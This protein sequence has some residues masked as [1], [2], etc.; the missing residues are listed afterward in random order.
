MANIMTNNESGR[1]AALVHA[2]DWISRGSF[3]GIGRRAGWSGALSGAVIAAACSTAA[4][5]PEGAQVVRG[6]V[7]ITRNGA[8]TLI[9]AGHN[10][11]INYRSFDIGSHESVRFIQPNAASRVL[12]RINSAAPTRIEGALSANGRVYI[13]NPAGVIFGNGARVN[14]AGLYA[15]GGKL[16]NADFLAGRNRFT[17]L[18]GEVANHGTITADFA[19]LIGHRVFNSGSI[20]APQGTV[21]MAAGPEV[22]VGE[23]TGNVFVKITGPAKNAGGAGVDNAGVVEAAGGRVMMGAGDMYSLAVRTTGRVK[24]K[25]IDVGVGKGH[26]TVSGTL[27]ASNQGAGETGG[28]VH[29]LGDSISLINAKIDASGANG[30]GQVR[31]GGDYLGQGDLARAKFTSVDKDSSISVSAGQQGDGGTAIV[32]SDQFTEYFGSADA[33]GGSQGGDGGLIETSSKDTVNL[34]PAS[35][36]ASAAKGQGGNWLIDPRDVNISDAA[37]AFIGGNP[38]FTPG[39]GG[40]GPSNVNIGTV[41]AALNAGTSVTVTTA[42]S[43]EGHVGNIVVLDSIQ[44]TAGGNATLTLT[45]MGSITIN[46]NDTGASPLEISS[47][48]GTLGVILQANA[49]GGVGHSASGSGAVNLNGSIITN[50]GVFTSSGVNFTSSG[51]GTI[52]TTGAANGAI[53]LTHTGTVAVGGAM[54]GGAVDIDSGAG[55]ISLNANITTGAGAVRFRDAVTLAT[56]VTIDTTSGNAAGAGITFDSTINGTAAGQEDLDL[57][58]GTG[59]NIVVTGAAGGT[60][61]LGLLNITNANNVNTGALTLAGMEQDAG[62]G[63]STFGGAIDTDNGGVVVTGNNFTFSGLV[64]TGAGGQLFST[65][66]GA[67]AI[68]AGASLDGGLV[69]AGGGTISITGNVTTTNDNI[70]I[71]DALTFGGASTLNAG[72]AIIAFGS[73]AAAGANNVILNA[74]AINFNGGANSVTGTGTLTLR[75]STDAATISVGAAGGDLE[76]TAADMAALA[77]GFTQINIGRATTGAHDI[78]IGALAIRD[79]MVF[80]ASATGGSVLVSGAITGS[81]DGAVTINGSGAT[82]TLDANIVTAGGAIQ[83]NDAVVLGTSVTLDTTNG[84]AVAAGANIGITGTIEATTDSTEALTM[85][86]GTGGDITLGGAVGGTQRLGGFTITS[87]DDVTAG[88]IASTFITQTLA[89]NSATYSGQLD[90]TDAAGIS[91][92][93]A[94]IS[95]NGSAT[96]TNGGTFSVNNSGALTIGGALNLDGA[97]TQTGAGAVTVSNNI[98][99]SND[100]VSFAANVT[101]GNDIVIDTN[102]G[103]GGDVTFSGTLNGTTAGADNLTIDAGSGDVFFTSIGQGTRI[104]ILTITTA[105]DVSAAAANMLRMV[106][107]AGTGTTSFSGTVDTSSGGLNVT[108]NNFTF[109]STINTTAG[110]GLTVVSTGALT[111]NGASTLDGSL[112][113]SGGGTAALNANVTT[114]NDNISITG[115]ATVGS[116]AQFTVGT[117]I[118]AFTGTVG[119][120][121]NN[122]TFT[123]DEINFNGGAGSVTGTGSIVLQSGTNG[124]T[125]NV[126]NAVN[127]AGE[128]D[129]Q[130][131]DINALADG[132]TQIT[133]GRNTGVQALNIS[134]S[135]FND[136]VVFRAGGGGTTTVAGALTG[137]GNASFTITGTSAVAVNAAVTTAGGNF[138]SAGTT[139]TSNGAGT[140]STSNGLFTLAHTGAVTLGGN[141][142]TG[143]FDVD[144]GAGGISLGASILTTGDAVRFRDAVTLTAD[145]SINTTS[146]TAVGNNITF[147]GTVSGTTSGAEDLTLVA[148]TGGDISFGGAVGGTRLGALAITSADVVTGSSVTAASFSQAAGT[149]STTLSGAVNTNAAG[150]VSLSGNAFTL[151]A[152]TTTGGGTFTANNSGT[153]TLGGT[154]TLDGA[155]SQTGAGATQ[156][157]AA[158]TTTNDNISFNGDVTV[159]AAIGGLN[160]GTAGLTFGGLLSLGANP[161]TLTGNAMAFNGG[162]DSVSGTGALTIQGAA[163]ATNIG[164][165]VDP[166]VGGL[167]LTNATW[168]ALADGFSG[169]TVGRSN[170]SGTM[171]LGT[172]TVRDAVVFQMPS[173]V[174]DVSGVITSTGAGTTVSLVGDT[175][176]GGGSGISTDNEAISIDGDVVLAAGTTT[177]D[178]SGAG[179]TGANIEITGAVT[180]AAADVAELEFDAGTTGNITIGGDTGTNAVPLL[181]FGVVSAN[182]VTTEDIFAGQIAQQAGGGTSTFGLLRS[183]SG[184]IILTGNNFD[185]NQGAASLAS[186][187]MT[188][189]NAGTLTVDGS[190]A[191]TGAFTQTGGGVALN[192]NLSTTNDNISIGGAT[193]AGGAFAAIN[194]GTATITLGSTFAMGAINGTFTANDMVFGGGADSISGTGQITLQP[195]AAATSIGIAGGAGTLQLGAADIGALADGFDRLTIGR[196]DGQHAITIGA[197]TFRDETVIRTPSGGTISVTGAIF[198]DGDASVSLTSAGDITLGANIVTAGNEITLTGPIVLGSGV[199]LDTTDGGNA[200]GADLTLA[201]TVQGTTAGGQSLTLD[202]GAGNIALG[203]N[204]G[205]T[206]RLGALSVTG[207]VLYS[208]ATTIRST[209]APF[210]DAVSG[211]DDL[212]I[213]AG[214]GNLTLNGVVSAGAGDLVLAGAAITQNAAVSGA[215]YAVQAQNALAINGDVTAT[216]A[217][218]ILLNA[219]LSGAGNLTF[220]AGVDVNASAMTLSAGVGTGTAVADLVTNSPVFRGAAGGATSPGFFQYRQDANI[221]GASLPVVAGQFGGG[222]A[223]MDYRINARNGTVTMD[224]ASR[225]AGSALRLTSTGGI[226]T[227]AD[228]SLAS[229]RATSLISYTGNVTTSNGAIQ[230]DAAAQTLGDIALIAG[231]GTITFS[232]TLAV[233]GSSLTLIAGDVEFADAVTPGAPVTLSIQHGDASKD[234]YLGG[235]GL[236]G[237]GDMHLTAAEIARLGDG[238]ADINIG[239]TDSTGTIFVRTAVTFQDPVA[240]VAADTGAA[241]RVEALLSGIDDAS[242]TLDGSGA[243]TVLLADIRTAGQA[244]T[245]NDKVI[246]GANVTL[247]TTDSGGVATGADITINGEVDADAA[248]QDRQLTLNSGT[249]GFVTLQ[250]VGLNERLGSLSA[251]GDEIFLLSVQTRQGQSYTGAV[252]LEGDLN[253]SVAGAINISGDLLVGADA[254]IETAGLTASDDIRITGTVNSV[255]SPR[256]LTM[257]AGQGSVGVGGSV[258]QTLA[259]SNLSVTG[260]NNEFTFVTTSNG[261]TY[262]GSTTIGGDLSGSTILFNDGLTLDNSV[263]MSGSIS[264]TLNTVLSAATEGNSLTINSPTTVFNGSIGNTAGG[265]LG[266]ITSDAGG[267]LTVRGAAVRSLGAQAYGDAVSLDANVTFASNGSVTFGSTINSA[268]GN[269]NLTVNTA[270]GMNTVFAGAIGQTNALGTLTTNAG[271]TAF[272]GGNVRTTG[273]QTINDAVILNANTTFQGSALTFGSTINSDATARALTFLATGGTVTVADA[274]GGT[275]ALASLSSTS[276]TASL[277]SVTTAGGQSITGALT[278]NGALA[279]TTNGTIEIT[280]PLT[281]AGDSSIT[282]AGG[283]GNNIT[284]TGEVNASPESALAVN[285]GSGNVNFI[286]NIGQTNRLSSLTVQAANISAHDVATTGAQSY[287]GVLTSDG[288]MDSSVA[289]DI[290][291][292]GNL[293]LSGDVTVATAA[294]NITYGGTVD[295]G[296]NLITAATGGVST[297]NGVVGGVTRL[298]TVTSNGQARLNGASV[299]TTGDQTYNAG[300]VLGEDVV[301]EAQDITFNGTIDSDDAG[302]PRALTVN[303]S[304]S[305]ETRFFGTVGGTAAL[306]RISTNADGITKVGTTMTTIGGMTFADALRITADSTLNGGAGSLFFRNAI[307]ADANATNPLLTLLSTAAADGDTTPFMFNA[308]IGATRQ[309]GGLTLGA[310]RSPP[311]G[312]TA[313][314]SD[315][316]QANGRILESSFNSADNFTIRTGDGGFTMGRGQKLTTFGSLNVTTT[317]IATLGDLTALTNIRVIANAIRIQLRGSGQVLDNVFETPTDLTPNDSGVDFIASG[318]IDFNVVPTTIGSGAAP[319]FSTDTGRADPQLF[320]LGHRQFTDG[321]R[322][323]LFR[324]PRAGRTGELMQID[325]KGEG[326]SITN[327]ATTLAGAIPRD[328]ETRQVA[329]PVTVGKALRDPL[330]EMGVATKDLSVDDLVEFMVGRSMYRDLPLKA[331]PTIAGG[332]YQVTVNRL[333]MSTVEAA[334]DSYRRLVFVEAVDENGQQQLDAEGRVVLVNRTETIRDTLG[335]AWDNYSTQTEEADGAGFRAYLEERATSGSPAEQQSLEFIRSVGEVLSRLDAL[336][337]SPFETSIPKRKLMNEIRP[338]AMTEEQLQMAVTGAQLSLR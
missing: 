189:A 328:S 179:S 144:S 239:R 309:L 57:N 88:A 62:G 101:L 152:V 125:I 223:G 161:F 209:G 220:G 120:G 331:R 113:F 194:A 153:L 286:S 36:D 211:N 6:Q 93:G 122:V 255:G 289:G 244:I 187:T 257:N 97:F 168:A 198:G 226:T 232:D 117:G 265:E 45:A 7:D 12:N 89:D 28:R 237:S 325:L 204:I 53:T 103:G 231:T 35:I 240:L 66:T 224:N 274:I 15:A 230:N 242:V 1:A 261:Q 72:T 139:F 282:S 313:V 116:S 172:F 22:M 95:V 262:T 270:A 39:N 154:L 337:L 293:I 311:R 246:V 98:S 249:A 234:I 147:D 317:G 16:S 306:A 312:A 61:R 250:D 158:L 84:G 329:T 81:T 24:A 43:N 283:V 132:F 3:L 305:G 46:A 27:D 175:S 191:L 155:F 151:A 25:G 297:F 258:G 126:G 157:N 202:S 106:Q 79:P 206:T 196:A 87:A 80:H 29:V 200:A 169:I 23:R 47:T 91:L 195:S 222:I 13:V 197:V 159:G 272:F 290:T 90:T 178:S 254:S 56:D 20:V 280:G 277:R 37:A 138:S 114:T 137:A 51:T 278:L 327:T 334:V 266:T 321:V 160:A 273:A 143:T 299:N 207:A 129:L 320:T 49:D 4:A 332:D 112:V 64:T 216:G 225:V 38:N 108:G 260:T 235:T 188:V 105:D 44:K 281:L 166:G 104:G 70:S 316:F 141:L 63:T 55:G 241:I 193:T 252:T 18:T 115:N 146:L 303:S 285:A 310:D 58:A 14:V 182:D 76:L 338:P 111:L 150:G 173:G 308:S 10:S 275:S 217:G 69:Q 124:V 71:A 83:I 292:T 302:S 75:P 135:T 227:I 314:F 214:S 185:L 42:G 94:A 219:G 259:L 9:R 127:N 2:A 192:A 221:N 212:T 92:T 213:D 48:T 110:S 335:E 251:T 30:G 40:S 318:F 322:I 100:A 140:F 77:N 243:S 119:L 176:F 85:R 17:N 68:G 315:G 130:T 19:G 74:D 109:G 256:N 236:E 294:G 201:G 267:T 162:A 78:T 5:G 307:D 145:V 324:D 170:G 190:I 52:N 238:F 203:G 276:G 54:T 210:A 295:G 245:I 82:T 218:G 50:G 99:T 288:V 298:T 128:L 174:I 183:G 171:S 333:S 86:A 96:T 60:T 131:T 32:W 65:N 186:G 228:L 229:L 148:G 330:Q 336:G 323:E 208:P 123:G 284:V 156:L 291:L 8:E 326:P 184:G 304:S 164:V 177:L 134:A 142:T 205:T 263:L 319:T 136:P 33:R 149:T 181:A 300:L 67:L 21:V 107:S 253:S 269:R 163:A 133:I 59:G 301:I 34:A 118:I 279:S 11:I 165:G 73:T 248:A 287:T 41:E 180:A 264:V 102:A 271:G 31:V 215:S 121:A 268:T 167:H 247:D 26:V 296:H 233:D 199:T